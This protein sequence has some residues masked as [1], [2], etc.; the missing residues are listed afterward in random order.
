MIAQYIVGRPDYFTTTKTDVR[1]ARYDR[2]V[3][4]RKQTCNPLHRAVFNSTIV[5]SDLTAE[6]Q[7][8][9]LK[10]TMSIVQLMLD[11]GAN[12]Q[13][14]ARRTFNSRKDG[15]PHSGWTVPS[16]EETILDFARSQGAPAEIVL[17]LETN[18]AQKLSQP[19]PVLT[20]STAATA[21]ATGINPT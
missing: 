8:D 6:Q 18:V 5:R 4:V 19:S 9:R 2:E 10:R 16:A 3:F 15:R 12:P 14:L 21:T 20:E 13:D 1:D 17:A 7:Q 11:Y